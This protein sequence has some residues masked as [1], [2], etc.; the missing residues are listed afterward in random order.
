MSTYVQYNQVEHTSS[1][2]VR[3][4]IEKMGNEGLEPWNFLDAVRASS[5]RRQRRTVSVG[6]GGPEEHVLVGAE[7]VDIF[8]M[9]VNG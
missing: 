8:K 9:I 4:D 1:L 7:K 5:T 2:G 6:G 3:V